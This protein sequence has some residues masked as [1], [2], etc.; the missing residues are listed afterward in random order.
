MD[1]TVGCSF[2]CQIVLNTSSRPIDEVRNK[3]TKK[4]KSTPFINTPVAS[5]MKDRHNV[6]LSS[7]TSDDTSLSEVSQTESQKTDAIK[8]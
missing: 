8:I 1:W 6:V 3:G 5:P 7:H 4:D 2:H